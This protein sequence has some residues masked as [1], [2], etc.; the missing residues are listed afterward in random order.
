MGRY[1][2]RSRRSHKGEEAAETE[3]V[4]QLRSVQSRSSHPPELIDLVGGL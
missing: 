2:K 3:N 1:V 4:S